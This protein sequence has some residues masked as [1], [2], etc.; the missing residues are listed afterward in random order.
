MNSPT[1]LGVTDINVT[2]IL[3]APAGIVVNAVC[4]SVQINAKITNAGHSFYY[5][6]KE[7]VE[8]L[9]HQHINTRTG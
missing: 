4:L 2:V 9:R 3:V 7:T 6:C 1:A 5:E 8:F